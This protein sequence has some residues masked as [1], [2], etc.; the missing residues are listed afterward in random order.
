MKYFIVESIIKNAELMDDNK[1]KE[2]KAY[3]QKAMDEGLILITGLKEDMSGVVF[4]MKS[5][6]IEKVDE[7]LNNEPF[8]IYGIQDYKVIEFS[9]HYINPSPG[10]WLK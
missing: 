7:Y 1:M 10:E 8:K 6:S 2:H 4:T 9:P 5:E 3:T